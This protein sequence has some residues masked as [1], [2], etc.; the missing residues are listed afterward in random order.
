MNLSHL[1]TK[2]CF[3]DDLADEVLRSNNDSVFLAA[4]ERQDCPVGLLVD[5]SQSVAPAVRRA[6]AAHSNTQLVTLR[7]LAQDTDEE[8]AQIARGRLT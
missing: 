2:K 1:T 4:L 7:R 3:D 6:V 8:V 5:L